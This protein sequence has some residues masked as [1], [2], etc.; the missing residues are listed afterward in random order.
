M[1][2]SFPANARMLL[3]NSAPK[4]SVYYYTKLQKHTERGVKNVSHRLSITCYLWSSFDL[5][6]CMNAWQ[7]RRGQGHEVHGIFAS[8]NR[9]ESNRI[10]QDK[11]GTKRE[12]INGSI[13]N[14]FRICNIFQRNFFEKV[15]IGNK[16][17]FKYFDKSG[18]FQK[19]VRTSTG[20]E[21]LR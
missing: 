17:E 7:R 5:H 18:Q 3:L 8:R 20:F 19:Q 10:F 2:F 13:F 15:R 16:I 14:I 12:R 21:F 4:Q 9:N 6:E 11:S 1:L